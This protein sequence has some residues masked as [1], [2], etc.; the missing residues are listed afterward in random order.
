MRRYPLGIVELTLAPL[1]GAAA[2]RRAGELG[3]D[4]LDAMVGVDEASLAIPLGHL[5]SIARPQS[6]CITPAPPAREGA[7]EWLVAKLRDAPGCMLEPWTGGCVDSLE[8]M[9]AIAE[10]VPGTRFLVDTG[11]VACWGGDPL[12]V[13]AFADAVQLRQGRPG[14]DQ[15]HVD[16]PTG[17]VDFAAVIARLDALEYAGRLSIEYYSL[18]E[19]GVV[20]EDPVGWSVDLAERVRPLIA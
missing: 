1:T 12:E 4:H 11:H 2:S 14:Q 3:F 5:I 17:I 20:V 10:E 13:L 16:D 19:H 15:L 18:P 8:S 6:G 7:W 9:K